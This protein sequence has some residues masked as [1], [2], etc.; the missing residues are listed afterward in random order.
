MAEIKHDNERIEFPEQKIIDVEMKKEVDYK[1]VFSTVVGVV[2][3]LLLI[4]FCMDVGL[5]SIKLS[6]LQLVA[7]IPI[8]SYVDPKSGKDGLFKKWYEMCFKTFLSLFI[9]IQREF[10]QLL[11]HKLK[12][13]G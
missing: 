13:G 6:F 10:P 3:V 5:R 9:R 11:K 2:V 12:N 8:L 4:N 1:F 7:P